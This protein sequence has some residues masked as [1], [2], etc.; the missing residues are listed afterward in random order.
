MPPGD[1]KLDKN[2][3]TRWLKLGIPAVVI[4]VVIFVL[5]GRMTGSVAKLPS[6]EIKMGEF[7][8]DLKE[9]GRM[10]AENSVTVSAPP[11]RGG[12]QIVD[13]VP[14]GTEIQ[15]GDLLV[16][17]DTT[18]FSESITDQLAELD[19]AKA[20]LR[21]SL[22]SMASSMSGMIANVEDA[23][24]SYRLSELRLDQMKF[25]AD[26]RIEEAKLNLLQADLSLKQAIDRVEAQKQI[27]AAEK[28][29]LNLRIRQAEIELNNTIRSRDK[30]RITAPAPGIVV[31]KEMWRGGEMAKIGIGDT[32]WRGQAMLEIPDMSVMM[33]ETTVSEID[34]SK[35]K[36]GLPVE[37][38]LDAFPDPTFTGEVVEIANI[39]RSDKQSSDAKV[40]DVV[41]RITEYDP[42]L[43]PG[44]TANVR[45]IIDRFEDRLWVPIE[46]IFQKD[47][48]SIVYVKRSATWK[49]RPVEIGQRNSNFV[50]IE[51][52]FEQG[53][54]VALIDPNLKMASD[55]ESG[56]NSK[57]QQKSQKRDAPR[58]QRQG[59]G[60]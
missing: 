46:S 4:L 6:A 30:L 52:E 34:V 14:E 16:Q 8:V 44:M 37:V 18:D 5:I 38:K 26:V 10:K 39:A 36:L 55:K 7:V 50:V 43:R 31:Y 2:K 28:E 47:A 48:Q 13:L 15:K 23:K 27:D 40:F 54:I 25:E 21:S 12:L 42:V 9:I 57:G 45:I 29:E 20:N 1:K 49:A 53:D 24:A 41:I 35:I 60:H 33:V 58:E 22:A 32:P 19:I 3:T 51:G 59:Q 17:F 56:D 11:I